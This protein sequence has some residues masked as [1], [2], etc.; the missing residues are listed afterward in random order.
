[1]KRDKYKVFYTY[2]YC[3]SILTQEF[4]N[5]DC[6]ILIEDEPSGLGGCDAPMY[7]M[8]V[9]GEYTIIRDIV[10]KHTPN[11]GPTGMYHQPYKK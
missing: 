3:K 4:V 1:M 10:D 11:L 5:N 7:F 9:E 6:K 8:I 2:S